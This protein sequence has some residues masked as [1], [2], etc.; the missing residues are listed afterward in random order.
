MVEDGDRVGFRVWNP[1]SA[2]SHTNIMMSNKHISNDYRVTQMERKVNRAEW[3]KSMFFVFLECLLTFPL[4]ENP[5][6][7]RC[8]AESVYRCL[9]EFDRLGGDGECNHL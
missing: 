4:F 9:Q 7:V 8:T 6:L 5:F 2:I 1:Q 3:N